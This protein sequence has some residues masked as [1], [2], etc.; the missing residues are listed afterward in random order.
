MMHTWTGRKPTESGMLDHDVPIIGNHLK[1]QRIALMV[2]GGIAAMKAPFLARALRRYEARITAYLSEEGARY[3]GVDA[4]EWATDNPVIRDLSARAEHLERADPFSAYVVAPATYNTINKMWNGAADSTI[5]T[6]LATA[7]GLLE[8]G[9]TQII[10]AP[11][12]H[13]DMHNAVLDRS[14]EGLSAMGVRFIEPRDDYGKHNFPEVPNIVAFICATLSH[15]PLKGRGVLVTA[16]ATP[17][18]IDAL[19]IIT[20]RFRG[21]LGIEIA[22]E[23]ALRGANVHL[24]LGKGSNTPPDFLKTTWISD[25][26]AYRETVLAT[27]KKDAPEFGFFSSAVADYQPT[28][29]YDG[30][31]PSGGALKEIP[32]KPTEKVIDLVA[33]AFPALKMISFKFE[34][35]IS[36]EDLIKKA[37]QRV[38]KGHLAVLAN[39]A[40]DMPHDGPHRAYLVTKEEQPVEIEGKAEI[41]EVMCDLIERFC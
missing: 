30:K 25:Y 38:D 14:F 33:K 28:K 9:K 21:R 12:M 16:G 27:L 7:L 32:L 11:T 36:P 15:S 31:V 13:G 18:R 17:V 24:I 39:R 1:G 4:L 26:D 10:V 37:R 29:I 23:L 40:E 20:N 5:T 8:Q 3:V 22:K 19:R 41:A 2:C 6:A 34:H 35:G